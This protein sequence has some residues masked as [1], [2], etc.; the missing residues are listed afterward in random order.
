MLPVMRRVR[1]SETAKWSEVMPRATT[2][3][4]LGTRSS[5]SSSRLLRHDRPRNVTSQHNSN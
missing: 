3:L 2:C 5:P 4:R 1:V